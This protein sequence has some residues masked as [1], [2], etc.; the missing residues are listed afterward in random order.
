MVAMLREADK[1]LAAASLYQASGRSCRWGSVVILLQLMA[2]GTDA[3]KLA[4]S[5]KRGNES[6]AS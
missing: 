2:N 3:D 4:A 5:F 6:G 1:G